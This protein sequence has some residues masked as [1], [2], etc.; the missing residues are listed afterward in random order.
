MRIG[1][2]NIDH[3]EMDTKRAGRLQRYTEICAYIEKQNCDLLILTETNSTIAFPGFTQYCSDESC[4]Y[5]KSRCYDPPNKYHQVA[6]LSKLPAEQVVIEEP[7]NGVLCK[8][9]YKGQPLY[10]YGNVIT[11]KDQWK[12]EST[13]KY[14][15]RFNEQISQFTQLLGNTFLIGGDFNLKKGWS[16]KKTAYEQVYDF[17]KVNNL[18]WPTAEETNS[19]QHVIHSDSLAT[20][21]EMDFSVKQNDGERIA[22]S[23]HPFVTIQMN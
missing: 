7:L 10:V 4:Y 8:V 21:I 6:I 5:K 16:Q 2:W 14:S 23:D 13:K 11:I 1:L 12:K 3:P 17:V 19:V 15:D 9:E 22:L 20:E 18:Q